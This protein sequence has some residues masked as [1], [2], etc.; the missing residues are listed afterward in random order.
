MNKLT[1]FKLWLGRYML[2]RAAKA[3]A[4]RRGETMSLERAGSV[5][6]VFDASTA[7]NCLR[8]LAFAKQLREDGIRQVEAFGWVPQKE[9][10]DFLPQQKNFHFGGLK[11]L[12]WF[13]LLNSEEAEQF[14]KKGF[15]ILL[16][17]STVELVPLVQLLGKTQARMKAGPDQPM[18]RPFLDFMIQIDEKGGQDT[19]IKGINHYLKTLTPIGNAR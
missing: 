2:G 10:P 11:G 8:V 17:V 12:S 6:I 3:A 15:D 1:E 13:G 19:L 18:K 7:E 16:D 14:Q 5:G 9:W 4:S